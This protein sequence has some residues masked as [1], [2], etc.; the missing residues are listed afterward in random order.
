MAITTRNRAWIDG[1]TATRLSPDDRGLA[2]GDGF[3]ETIRFVEGRAPLWSGHMTRLAQ[4]CRRLRIRIPDRVQLLTEAQQLAGARD[5][6]IKI[7]ITRSSGHGYAGDKDA[8][9]RRV[10]MARPLPDIDAN[11]Y[12]KGVRLRWCGLRL[13]V[14]PALAGLKHLNR[15]EQVLARSEW[16]DPRIYDGL[17]CDQEG[18]VISATSANVF[19]VRRGVLLT[20][21][22]DRCGV[23]GVARAWILRRA[24]RL[25][26]VRE[27]RLRAADIE[28]AD[29]VFLSNA[30]RGIVPV[31]VLAGQRFEIGPVTQ[32]LGYTLAR[33]GIG[34]PPANGS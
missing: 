6:V 5:G 34:L 7:I 18:A 10:V 13:C 27:T 28:S 22:I 33:L 23:A 12:R 2:Y 21:K 17:L 14:Q 19:I 3:F 9:A 20:P 1:H 15:L 4:G 29:E 26:K 31:R 24:A 25:C 11:A 16:R 30:V 32:R 8:A